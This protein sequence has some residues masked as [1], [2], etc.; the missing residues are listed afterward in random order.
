VTLRH[1]VFDFDGTCTEIPLADQAFLAAYLAAL[2]AAVGPEQVS[3]GEW[4]DA[5]STVRRCSPEEGW[6]LGGAPAAPAAA[7]P[8]V[9]AYETGALLAH[10]RRL[11]LPGD[12]HTKA[13]QHAEAPL[14]AEL[15]E[16][17]AAV[18][19]LGVKITF[20]SNSSTT[21]V[22]ARLDQAL[23][24]G[25]PLRRKI[26][27]LGDASKFTIREPSANFD[28]PIDARLL[29]A[30]RALPAEGPRLLQRPIYLRRGGYFALLAKVW[31]G[32]PWG[33]SQTLVCGDIW[34][35]DLALPAALGCAV[36]LIERAPPYQTCAY[37]LEALG[38]SLRGRS[39]PDLRGLLAHAQALRAVS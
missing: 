18:D 30:F 6:R 19:A 37:E 31:G 5:L 26:G 39:S 21:V 8:Y 14:R 13:L 12:L 27:V 33:P 35:L 4:G 1:L 22:G 7:D 20:I 36:H 15:P 11:K 25:S 3:D 28:G 23:G 32:D 29:A 24:A 17:L 34:E 10:R 2:R 16:V 38:L 9:L